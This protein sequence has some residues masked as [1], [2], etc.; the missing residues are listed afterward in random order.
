MKIHFFTL[1]PGMFDSFL[2]ESIMKRAAEKKILEARVHNLRDYTHDRHRTC[3]DKPFGGGPGMLMKPEP[4]FEAYDKVFGKRKTKKSFRFIYLSPQG[5]RFDQ[6]KAA[7]LA[8]VKELAFLC[9]HYEGMD[10][11]VIDELVDEEISIGDYVLTQGELPAMVVADSVVR[12]IKGVVGNEDSKVFESFSHNLL[13][14]PQYTRPSVYR[15]LEV[16]AI[17]LSGD[18][19]KID[20]WRRREAIKLTKKRRPDLL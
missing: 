2:G 3:D 11:R 7:E 15:G 13:E 14:Y 12:L 6:K 10:Q 18:H 8:K 5:K 4:V 17:L 16:P 20:Q 19:Q 9:G 1:F